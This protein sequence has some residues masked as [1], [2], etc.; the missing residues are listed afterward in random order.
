MKRHP[1]KRLALHTETL[2]HLSTPD[3][4]RADGGNTLEDWLEALRRA[5]IKLWQ[6]VREEESCECVI[7]E[8]T[9]MA[10]CRTR[11]CD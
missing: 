9:G 10:T 5:W 4:R 6:S 3:L 8:S 2:R 1:R 11:G 7:M